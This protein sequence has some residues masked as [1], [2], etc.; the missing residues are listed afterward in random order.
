MSIDVDGN[1]YHIF[2][3]LVRYRPRLLVIEFNPDIPNDVVFIQDRDWGV[4]QGCSLRAMVELG[5]ER[6]CELCA[7]MGANAF[8][9]DAAEFPKLGIADN[10]IDSMY[11]PRRDAKLF[12]LFDG[13]LGN[14]GLRAL[15]LRQADRKI[16]T[17]DPFYFQHYPEH[18][19]GYGGA[20]PEDARPENA[21]KS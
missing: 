2:H 17:P 3:S 4:Q 20:V 13:T 11:F 16:F 10:Q 14:I 1:D 7:I 9:V 18:E 19:R 6:N 12:Q 8:L 15:A 5:K 21:K